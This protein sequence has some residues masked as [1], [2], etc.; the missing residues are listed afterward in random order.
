MAPQATTYR[1]AP[2]FTSL[3]EMLDWAERNRI[4]R[5]HCEQ[6]PDGLLRGSGEVRDAEFTEHLEGT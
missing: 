6:G 2:A 5:P 4:E 3:D 1:R